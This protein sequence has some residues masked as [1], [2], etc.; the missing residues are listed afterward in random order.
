M[1]LDGVDRGSAT[2]TPMSLTFSHA[3][4]VTVKTAGLSVS[5]VTLSQAAWSNSSIQIA[6]KFRDRADAPDAPRK[7]AEQALVHVSPNRVEA[8]LLRE[9]VC[10]S[11]GES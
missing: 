10:P 4:R 7:V 2:A 5:T 8:G 3:T 1:T 6:T 9:L 11:G